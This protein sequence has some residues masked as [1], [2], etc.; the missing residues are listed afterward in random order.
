M[1]YR[2]RF[3]GFAIAAA[4]GFLLPG[5]AAASTAFASSS[6]NI[7]QI[8]GSVC[9][10]PFSA[11]DSGFISG[12]VLQTSSVLPPFNIARAF[13]DLSTGNG[14]VQVESNYGHAQAQATHDDTWFCND[15]AACATL[16]AG[17]AIPVT[18]GLHISASGS[19]TPQGGFMEVTYLYG[20]FG[21]L[22]GGNRSGGLLQFSFDEDPGLG[23]S[24]SID[25]NA[26]FSDFGSG[27]SFNIPVIFG[28][29]CFNCGQFALS[30]NATVT[31]MIG[32]CSTPGCNI[33]GGVFDDTQQIFAE[34]D[35]PQNHTPQGLD[36]T[37]SFDIA[38]D[39][40]LPLVSAD[41]R[42]VAPLSTPEPASFWLI[43]LGVFLVGGLTRRLR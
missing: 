18:I 31:I 12:N 11:S 37:H 6:V 34:N 36:S 14:G 35:G 24:A 7:P 28:Q 42:T 30:A 39:S 2:S 23:P 32:G 22:D 26:S 10:G 38:I 21:D 33:S 25:A 3:V 8:C 4:C 43:G 5:R 19:L 27:R 40:P 41:G 29:S 17:N 1:Y 20:I 15:P 13:I 16:E 9:V